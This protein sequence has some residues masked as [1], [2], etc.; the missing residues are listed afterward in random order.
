MSGEKPALFKMKEI[1]GYMSWLFEDSD[2]YA[3]KIRKVQKLKDYDQIIDELFDTLEIREDAGF[4][5]D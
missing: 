2:K 1:W 4:L 3:K 5:A